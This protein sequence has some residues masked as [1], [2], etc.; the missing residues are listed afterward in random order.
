MASSTTTGSKARPEQD[1]SD[2][3]YINLSI[4]LV[5]QQQ[6]SFYAEEYR[7]SMTIPEILGLTAL[8]KTLSSAESFCLVSAA[9]DGEVEV[10]G[11]AQGKVE[12]VAGFYRAD[13]FGGAGHDQVAGFEGHAGGN[14]GDEFGEAE[15]HGAQ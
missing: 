4:K 5:L 9:G 10:A 3:I 7:P 14:V 6:S 2:T 15:D 1:F 8:L 13:A 11:A 12:A